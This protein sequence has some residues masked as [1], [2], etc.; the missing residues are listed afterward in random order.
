MVKDASDLLRPLLEGE[1]STIAGR[2]AGALRNIGR[3][4]MAEEIMKTMQAAGYTIRVEDPFEPRSGSWTAARV[5]AA[6][7]LARHN[8]A[9]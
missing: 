8:E 4:R 7:C 1:H 9:E 6:W 3:E 2:L 5:R